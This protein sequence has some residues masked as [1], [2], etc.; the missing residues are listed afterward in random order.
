MPERIRVGIVGASP[1]S[2]AMA[3][4][5]PALAHL[6][7]FTVTA[8]ATTRQ[9]SARAAADMLGIVMPSRAPT[10]W[11][12]IPRVDLVVASVKVAC[13]RRRGRGRAGRGQARVRGVAARGRPG[14]GQRARRRRLRRG[15]PPPVSCTP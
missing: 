15:R 10:S 9:D 8:V 13:P 11:P 6:D 14:R 4:H 3:A 7:E 2:W 1:Q 5:M 12:R